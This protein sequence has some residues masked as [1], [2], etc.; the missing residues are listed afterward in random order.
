[1]SEPAVWPKKNIVHMTPD[2]LL[3]LTVGF[4]DR[5]DAALIA[6]RLP[7]GQLSV[8]CSESVDAT[9]LATVIARLLVIMNEKNRS[10]E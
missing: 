3:R 2:M 8:D 6:F 4:A 1:M 10:K 7:N 5:M 9:M